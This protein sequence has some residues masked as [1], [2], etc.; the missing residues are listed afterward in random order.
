MHRV[1]RVVAVKRSYSFKSTFVSP[2]IQPVSNELDRTC[3]IVSAFASLAE[4]ASDSLLVS[5][6]LP[7]MKLEQGIVDAIVFDH[8]MPR[9]FESIVC[10]GEAASTTEGNLIVNDL[11]FRAKEQQGQSRRRLN[12][13]S[14]SNVVRETS[15][16]DRTLQDEVNSDV[17]RDV[18]E[19]IVWKVT[20]QGGSFYFE[21]PKQRTDENARTCLLLFVMNVAA[22]PEI[23]WLG[24]V[25]G[26]VPLNSEAQWVSQSRQQ[27]QRPF[28]DVG[29]DGTGQVIGVS[30]TGL[31]TDNCYFWDATGDVAQDGVS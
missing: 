25:P 4:S 11:I 20:D 5:P 22:Q 18:F 31:D 16:Y 21:L 30:D 26:M 10:P 19:S 27:E 9:K 3:Y 28:F 6:L 23:S 29:L 2:T 8:P 7:E 13:F 14:H 12:V 1:H 15:D 17:C 24:I